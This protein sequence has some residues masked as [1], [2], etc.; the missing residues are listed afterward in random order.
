MEATIELTK[1]NLG[2]IYLDKNNYFFLCIDPLRLKNI[3]CPRYCDL[4]VTDE[5]R[6]GFTPFLLKYRLN[7]EWTQYGGIEWMYHR[8]EYDSYSWLYGVTANWLTQEVLTKGNIHDSW[9][10]NDWKTI[11]LFIKLRAI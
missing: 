7:S 8:K 10:E 1:N 2:Q 4:I 6:V 11:T 3:R 9:P 5:D